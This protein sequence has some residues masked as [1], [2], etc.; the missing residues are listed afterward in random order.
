MNQQTSEGHVGASTSEH[1]VF[2]SNVSCSLAGKG[3]KNSVR[4]LR[5]NQ[6]PASEVTT[7][8]KP[9]QALAELAVAVGSRAFW[10]NLR[11]RV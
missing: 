7:P 5:V 6:V 4:R 2:R 9:V 11:L 1:G 8:N 10:S 3:K